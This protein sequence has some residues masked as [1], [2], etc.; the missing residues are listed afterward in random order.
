MATVE[1]LARTSLER[2]NTADWEGMR[3]EIGPDFVYDEAGTGR[4][5]TDADGLIAALQQWK[6]GLPDAAGTLERMI[7]DGDTVA[8]EV[9][10]R[11]THTGTLATPGGELPP[12]GRTIE[13]WATIWQVWH[14]GR[15]ASE[16]HHIDLL[17]M[18]AQLG[19]IPVAA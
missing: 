13:V 5:I 15:M 17:S 1:E 18:L 19:A 8:M 16:R 2:F 3:S 10:W 9:V 12:T 7:V 6:A 4:R 11:A 14:D